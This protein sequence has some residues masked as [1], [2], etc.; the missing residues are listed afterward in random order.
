MRSF[1]PVRLGTLERDAWAAYYLRR[2]RPFLVAAVGLV[3]VG[4][5]MPWPRTVRGAW[6][7]LRANQVW[8]PYPANDPAAARDLMTRFYALVAQYHGLGLDPAEAARREVAWWQAHRDLQHAAGTGAPVRP[9]DLVDAL[10]DVYAYVYGAEPGLVTEAARCRAAAMQLSDA[11]VAAGCPPE[12][13]RL[14]AG[15]DL[16]VRGYAALRGRLQSDS[17]RPG[18]VAGPGAA[19]E[20]GAPGRSPSSASGGPSGPPGP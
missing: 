10:A 14:E 11:W 13:P 15:R 4:F 17:A 3:R 6:L 1:D 7:V 5:G 20:P 2:W 16:L 19:A 12:D 18:E 8:A 9:Q